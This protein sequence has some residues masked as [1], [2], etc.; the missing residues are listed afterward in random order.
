M[1]G[2]AGLPSPAPRTAPPSTA[3]KSALGQFIAQLPPS[4][5]LAGAPLRKAYG[6]GLSGRLQALLDREKAAAVRQQEAQPSGRS[7]AVTVLHKQLEA[8]IAKCVC[9]LDPGAGAGLLQDQRLQGERSSSGAADGPQGTY[10][11]HGAADRQQAVHGSHGAA[12]QQPP[13]PPQQA[14]EGRECERVVVLF[15][16]KYTPD[17]DLQAGSRVQLR[18]PWA[19]SWLPGAT[20]PLVLAYNAAALPPNGL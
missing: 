9:R 11:S 16:P 5:A 8:G 1:Q 4:K 3:A 12:G 10:N 6:G 18:E 20:L 7:V 17:L 14:G 15:N 2:A 19:V 13:Q